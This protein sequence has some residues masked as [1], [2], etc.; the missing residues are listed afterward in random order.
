MSH[1]MVQNSVF[2]PPSKTARG[3]NSKVDI[4]L[5]YYAS[6]LQWGKKKVI[7]YSFNFTL[8]S[9]EGSDVNHSDIMKSGG[10][11][12]DSRTLLAYSSAKLSIPITCVVIS[13]IFTKIGINRNDLQS[14][15][16]S[17]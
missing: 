17:K 15:K 8:W 7:G 9:K 11:T 3:F 5:R 1:E 14:N 4:S 12:L 13:Q 16:F 10:L 6:S 2:F